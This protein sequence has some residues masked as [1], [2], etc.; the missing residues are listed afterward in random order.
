MLITFTEPNSGLQP[1]LI[2]VNLFLQI[3]GHQYTS[4]VYMVCN[5]GVSAVLNGFA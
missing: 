2:T 5:F 4:K 3:I 1:F